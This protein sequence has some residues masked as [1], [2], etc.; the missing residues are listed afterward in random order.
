MIF[1]DEENSADSKT[2]ERNLD[3]HCTCGVN[4]CQGIFAGDLNYSF[5]QYA[6]PLDVTQV[7]CLDG[8]NYFNLVKVNTFPCMSTALSLFPSRTASR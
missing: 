1:N 3:A 2:M 6:L 8:R 7:I 5:H 4:S